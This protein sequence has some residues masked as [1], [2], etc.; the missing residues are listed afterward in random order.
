MSYPVD[1]EMVK[2]D[3]QITALLDKRSIV[4]ESRSGNHWLYHSPI[5]EDHHASF[6]VAREKN[7][8]KD[9]ATGES[10]SVLDLAILLGYGRTPLEAAKALAK[11]FLDHVGLDED[12]PIKKPATAI[13]IVE[14]KP[15]T[16]DALIN[17][18]T[19]ERC[20]DLDVA[21]RYLVEVH[22]Y[23]DRQGKNFFAAG[24]KNELGGYALRNQYIKNASSPAGIT[25]IHGSDN[26]ACMVFEGFMDFLSACCHDL[27]PD[28][29]VV[30]LN[31]TAHLEMA[32]TFLKEHAFIKCYL[33]NDVSG[34]AAFMKIMSKCTNSVVEDGSRLYVGFNDYNEFWV[35]QCSKGH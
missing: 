28:V 21:K 5:R 22:Y 11:E 2:R 17:Y 31:S 13:H 8:F 7:R 1:F 34:R 12:E 29:D 19:R 35:A 14:V 30:I 25:I 10:G 20:I 27:P 26:T 24:I 32:L 6:L 4:P 23:N 33:D 16:N 15:L 18:I 3:V 9:L